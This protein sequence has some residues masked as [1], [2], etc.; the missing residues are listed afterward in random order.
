MTAWQPACPPRWARERGRSQGERARGRARE[1]TGVQR[2]EEGAIGRGKEEGQRVARMQ[3]RRR[4]RGAA[5]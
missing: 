1:E 4:E 2:R 5:S 3:L